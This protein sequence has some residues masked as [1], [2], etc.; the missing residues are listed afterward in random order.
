ME[1]IENGNLE[2]NG[3][4]AIFR[5]E[6]QSFFSSLSGV[7]IGCG[8]LLLSGLFLWVFKGPFNVFDYGFADLSQFFCLAPWVFLFLIPALSMKSLSE[9]RKLG[10]ME[11][12]LIKPFGTLGLLAGKFLAVFAIAL[13]TLIPT[14][15]YIWSLS[16]LGST[17]ANYDAG[18]LLGSYLGLC[19]L[20][21]LYAAIGVFASALSENQIVSFLL[22]VFL[23]FSVYFGFEAVATIATDGAWQRKIGLLGAKA[24]FERIGRGVLD[25]KDVV[26]FISMTLFFLYMTHLKLKSLWQR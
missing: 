26:Y 6:F 24:H 12:L 10:T 11:L 14:V 2:L 19:L 25:V 18:V 21:L 16:E 9:E 22:A 4:L 20:C 17:E 15:V 7:L 3:M 5:K 13:M 23:C 1:R 8:F